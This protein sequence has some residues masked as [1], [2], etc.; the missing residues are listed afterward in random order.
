MCYENS[1][2]SQIS[3]RSLLISTT[4]DRNQSISTVSKLWEPLVYP[5]FFPHGT[6]GWGIT[7]SRQEASSITLDDSA[8]NSDIP[9]TQIWHYR[10]RLLREPRF[11]I[12]GRLTNEYVVDMFSRELDAR[13][14][15]I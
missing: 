10:V 8:G 13:L 2:R 9:T 3:P 7:P 11:S 4:N 14:S 1:L 15:Y 12:L 5:L 6:L